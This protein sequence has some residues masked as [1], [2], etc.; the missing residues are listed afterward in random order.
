[1][2]FDGLH[3]FRYSVREGTPA[4]K[5]RGTVKKDVKKARIHE[6]LEW[7]SAQETRFA[8]RYMGQALP[9]LWEQVSGASEAG[10]IQA[11]YTPNYI[12]VQ[13]VHPRVL[14]NLITPAIINTVKDGVADVSPV[15]E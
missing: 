10:Y 11:G 5:M 12:R 14:S 4:A 2:D 13:T 9:V 1:M 15:I 6:L 3:A 8:E 7:A